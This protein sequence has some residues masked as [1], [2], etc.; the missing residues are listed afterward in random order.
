MENDEELIIETSNK[1]TKAISIIIVITIIGMIGVSIYFGW[2]YFQN[3]GVR[4]SNTGVYADKLMTENDSDVFY[5]DAENGFEIMQINKESGDITD[6]CIG[7]G[8]NL[9]AY[10]GFL[11]YISLKD[12]LVY[13]YDFST[14]KSSRKFDYEV[15]EFQ[16]INGSIYSLNTVGN[17]IIIEFGNKNNTVALENG[18]DIFYTDKYNIY[19]LNSGKVIKKN[20]MKGTTS[21][22]AENIYSFLIVNSK[23]IC[24]TVNGIEIFSKDDRFLLVDG[25]SYLLG[26]HDNMIYYYKLNAIYKIN[27]DGTD[28]NKLCKCGDNLYG[29]SACSVKLLYYTIDSEE[30]ILLTKEEIQ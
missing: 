4:E 22:L 28:C 19:Y 7:E 5:A 8:K 6:L 20:I 3:N 15:K 16:V 23:C 11:L 25:D 21:I 10:K 30:T 14:K 17:E 27:I 2:T 12:M 1:K 9:Y 26:L 18:T 24:E 13:E 29:F